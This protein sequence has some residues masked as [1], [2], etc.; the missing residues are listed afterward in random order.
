[1]QF[2]GQGDDKERD[3]SWLDGAVVTD[4]SPDGANLAFEEAGESAGAN[5][6]EVDIRRTDGS[7][8]VKLGRGNNPAF[9]PDGKWLLAGSVPFSKF[10]IFSTGSGQT[11]QLEA[12]GI[13]QISSLG[14]TPDGNEIYF[15]GNDGEQWRVYIQD[16]AGGAPRAITPAV[17]PRAG[18]IESDLVSLDGKYIFARDL[19]GGGLIYPLAGGGPTGVPGMTPED[20]WANW[21]SDGKSAYVYQNMKVYALVFRLDLATGE[22]QQLMQVAPQDIAG[23]NGLA[24][25][26]ITPDGKAYAYTYNRALSTLFVAD[27]V[28]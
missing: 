18:A 9:S 19:I 1:L 12:P 28:K 26:R 16:I 3:L 20:I 22:R 25:L 10:L 24:P 7:S 15:V 8:P 23:V 27:G 2:R 4:I 14:W 6:F 11:K 17:L 13:Q 5:E 21:A